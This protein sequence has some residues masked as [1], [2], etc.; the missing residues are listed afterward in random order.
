MPGSSSWRAL[1]CAVGLSLSFTLGTCDASAQAVVSQTVTLPPGK[2]LTVDGVRGRW[3]PLE[4]AVR[5]AQ[6]HLEVRELRALQAKHAEL[7][8]TLEARIDEKDQHAARLQKAG[9]LSEERANIAEAAIA[10]AE[11]GRAEAEA[12]AKEEERRARRWYR[13]PALWFSLGAIL[14]ASCTGAAFAA[15]SD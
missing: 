2:L 8:Q 12:H 4:T 10:S 5:L 7:V 3:W 1:T 6:D 9:E 11:R 13:H 14:T 15:I